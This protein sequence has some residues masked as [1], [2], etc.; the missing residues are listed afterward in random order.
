M[1]IVIKLKGKTKD[2]V[3]RIAT[4]NVEHVDKIIV[5]QESSKHVLNDFLKLPENILR[6]IVFENAKKF[7]E[8]ELQEE[9]M[10]V[11]IDKSLTV[12]RELEL[13]PSTHEQYQKQIMIGACTYGKYNFTNED[14]EKAMQRAKDGELATKPL[15]QYMY[16]KW[17][18]ELY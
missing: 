14:I 1:K 4:F 2:F 13:Y 15:N 12:S 7:Y 8:K 3:A 16:R 17:D 9:M 18:K 5:L 11:I 10:T 6:K